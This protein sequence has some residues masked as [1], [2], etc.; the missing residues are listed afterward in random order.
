MCIVGCYLPF[1]LYF[2]C[3]IRAVGR[4]WNPPLRVNCTSVTLQ[5]FD[6]INR[7]RQV[8]FLAW[9]IFF[10][11]AMASA[12]LLTKFKNLKSLWPMGVATILFLYIID[13]TFISLGAYGYHGTMFLL[14]NIPIFYL[15]SGFPGGIL[16]AYFYPSTKK[17]QLPYILLAALLFLLLEIIMNW[18]GYIHYINWNILRSYILDVGAFMSLLWLG[19][20]LNATGKE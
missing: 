2:Y 14:N 6:N 12:F 18:F 8:E 17:F 1:I 10:L 13:S 3:H 20:W 16:L 15:L 19:Q 4:I 9:I 5:Y 7:K 11:I